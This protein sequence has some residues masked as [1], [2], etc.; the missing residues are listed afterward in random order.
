MLHAPYLFEDFFMF[1]VLGDAFG[2]SHSY[3]ILILMLFA[4]Y[5]KGTLSALGT[6]SANF[7][8]FTVPSLSSATLFKVISK[9][10]SSYKLSRAGYPCSFFC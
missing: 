5:S 9:A 6:R 3:D 1:S 10:S 7:F 2:Y 4:L 8:R